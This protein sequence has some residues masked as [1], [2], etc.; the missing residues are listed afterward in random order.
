MMNF[1]HF[2]ELLWEEFFYRTAED[3]F[4]SELVAYSCLQD[5]QG[6]AVPRHYA[7]GN[8]TVDP[9]RPISPRV[10]ALEHIPGESLSTINP[11]SDP[12]RCAHSHL[13]G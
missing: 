13:T 8:L 9:L 12:E 10:I 11:S 3:A 1:V 4:D 5:L 7:S 6:G 2:D